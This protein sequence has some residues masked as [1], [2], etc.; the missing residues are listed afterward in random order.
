MQSGLKVI[1]ASP[2]QDPPKRSFPHI[3]PMPEETPHKIVNIVIFDD[4]EEWETTVNFYDEPEDVV[5][6]SIMAAKF[7]VQEQIADAED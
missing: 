2:I 6:E 3:K 7:A 1:L 4:G 5:R